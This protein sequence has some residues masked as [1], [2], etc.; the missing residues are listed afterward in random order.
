MNPGNLGPRPGGLNRMPPPAVNPTGQT[1]LLRPTAPPESKM[2]KPEYSDTDDAITPHQ[3]MEAVKYLCHHFPENAGMINDVMGITTILTFAQETSRVLIVSSLV[4]K[5]IA[6]KKAR[7]SE[8]EKLF[9][10]RVRT[11]IEELIAPDAEHLRN[12]PNWTRAAKLTTLADRLYHV[13]EMER[14][15]PK[16]AQLDRM[17]KELEFIYALFSKE[18]NRNIEEA[19]REYFKTYVE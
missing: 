17:K 2:G 7:L 8:I 13:R 14:V 9:G 11:A 4:Y 19:M 16:S 6:E 5:T 10:P 15:N 18:M 1:V 12:A 3:M